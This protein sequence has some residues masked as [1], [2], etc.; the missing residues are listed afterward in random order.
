L[1]APGAD[2]QDREITHDTDI[3]LEI[4]VDGK[5]KEDFLHLLTSVKVR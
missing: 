3:C 2:L 1:P 4:L 5:D